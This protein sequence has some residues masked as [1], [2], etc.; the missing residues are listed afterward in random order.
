MAS[1]PIPF[2]D[3]EYL[4]VSVPRRLGFGLV[5]VLATLLVCLESKK[6]I[7]LGVVG[8]REGDLLVKDKVEDR[9]D[10]R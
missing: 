8:A 5:I 10:E 6:T 2:P 4:F 1:F 7:S 9:I 3:N